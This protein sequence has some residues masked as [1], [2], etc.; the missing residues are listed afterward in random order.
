MKN[1]NGFTLIEL[2]VVISII[3]LL[4]SIL[5]PALGRAR[6]QA[7]VTVCASRQ[8]QNVYGATMAAKDNN[9][10][11][12]RGGFNFGGHNFDDAISFRAE[13]YINLTSY[14]TDLGVSIDPSREVDPEI[15]AQAAK[16][17]LTSSARLNFV[18]PEMENDVIDL[19]ER[20]MRSIIRG[21]KTAKKPFIHKYGGA[22]WTARIGYSYVAGFDT[23]EWEEWPDE[24]EKWRSP[25]KT[26]DKGS[27]TVIADRYRYV[28]DFGYFVFVHGD[29]GSGQEF[30][31]K[32]LTPEKAAEKGGGGNCVTNVGRLDG[33]VTKDKVTNLPGRHVTQK[34]NKMWSHT[35]ADFCYF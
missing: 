8:K 28:P 21:Q 18:C 22:G 27:L 5:M 12:P 6:A 10:K 4:M 23:L 13:E 7:R 15:L 32:G 30:V 29:S 19:E 1:K 26:T 9:E 14:V 34:D 20:G 33:S 16:Q 3:A 2:L 35:S 31:G 25:M 11:L 17:V 24:G